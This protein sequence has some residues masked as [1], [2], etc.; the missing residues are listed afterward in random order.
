MV[1]I[2]NGVLLSFKKKITCKNVNIAQYE[3]NANQNFKKVSP[4]TS[5]DGH[6]WKLYKQ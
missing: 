4:H 1:H 2:H 6:R 3:R 5:Q